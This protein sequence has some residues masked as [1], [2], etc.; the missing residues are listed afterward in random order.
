MHPRGWQ[1]LTSRRHLGGVH[2][3]LVSFAFSLV[4]VHE[5]GRLAIDCERTGE[6]EP[7]LLLGLRLGRVTGGLEHSTDRVDVDLQS[8]VRSSQSG[9]CMYRGHSSDR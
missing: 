5:R 4:G 8:S 6:D 9:F 3:S 7:D 1:W 2:L